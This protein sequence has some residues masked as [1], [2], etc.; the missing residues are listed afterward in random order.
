MIAEP[1][2]LGDEAR[3]VLET[4]ELFFS[5]ASSWEIAIKYAAGKLPLPETPADYIPSRL[6]RDGIAS[7]PITLDHAHQVAALPLHHK[8]PFDRLL[9]AQS[10]IEGLPLL[11]SDEA[12]A[13]YDVATIAA[14]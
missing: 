6:V 7:L 1:E 8:D 10:Q 12:M 5:A 4:G 9:I 14:S 13:A 3:S 2:R 11:T